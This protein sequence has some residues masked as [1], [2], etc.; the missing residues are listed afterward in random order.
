[1]RGHDRDPA[2]A[3]ERQVGEIRQLCRA[4]FDRELDRKTGIGGGGKADGIGDP[5]VGNGGKVDGLVGGGDD[6]R[7]VGPAFPDGFDDS[8]RHGVGAGVGGGPSEAVVGDFYNQTRGIGGGGNG[9]R[10]AVVGLREITQE[11]GRGDFENME[12]VGDG[13]GGRPV[14]VAGLGGHDRDFA[15]AGEGQVGE[16][17]DLRRAGN[18]RKLD[19]QAGIGRGGEFGP[20]GDPLVGDG[21]IIDGLRQLVAGAG[22]QEVGQRR[23]RIAEDGQRRLEEP[24]GRRRERDRKIRRAADFDAG[25][26]AG[27]LE[28][29]GVRTVRGPAGNRHVGRAQIAQGEDVGDGCAPENRAEIVAFRA[30]RGFGIGDGQAV[31]A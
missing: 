10:R 16:V 19:G 26:N 22:E 8:A 23:G 2:G 4:G 18:D 27:H 7:A 28:A 1:M 25:R 3:G 12:D 31:G 9:A 21:G 11:D 5:L 29:A 14:G 15:G 13:R 6:E 30:V 24:A 20:I 17:R